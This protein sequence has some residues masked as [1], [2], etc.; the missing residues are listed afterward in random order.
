MKTFVLSFLLCLVVVAF[1]SDQPS[2]VIELTAQNFDEVLKEHPVILIEFYAPWCGHCKRLAPEYEKAATELKG[3]APIA[4]MDADAAE[5]RPV[6]ARFG[7]QGFPTIKLFRNGEV[8]QDYQSERTAP[9]IVSYMKKQTLPAVST[10]TTVAEVEEFSTKDRVVVVGFFQDEAQ[11]DSF[12]TI[13]E[14]LRNRFI[15]GAVVGNNDVN[16]EFGVE[17]TP[18]AVLFKSFDE[19]KNVLSS[20]KFTDL[21]EFITANSVPVI[22][23]IGPHNYKNYV[24]SGLPVAYLFVEPAEAEQLTSSVRSIAEETKG[25]LSWVWIDWT[26]FAKHAERLG[27]A[28]KT[29]PAL[30]IEKMQEGL[31]YAFDE[32][33]EVTPEAVKEW[34]NKFLSGELQPTIKSEEIPASNDGP[35]KVVVAKNFND[36]VLDNTKDVLLEFYAPWCGHCK[37]LAPTYEKLGEAFSDISSVVIAKIDATAND[38]DPKYGVRGFPTI[39][40]FPADKKNEPVDYNGERTLEDM[41]TFIEENASVKFELP[42]AKDEL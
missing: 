20:D 7:I 10:L 32:T 14:K 26:K 8:D 6:A 11:L 29:V 31:H 25:R 36:V 17:S 33:A 2:D 34:V 38:I 13:A 37:S 35:V 9:A 28:G 30:A 41:K 12:K 15:F 4:K 16:K 21:E 18:G 3:I 24:E 23:E 27:L 42:T 5:N 40:F 1:A 22:D 19:R 39:K